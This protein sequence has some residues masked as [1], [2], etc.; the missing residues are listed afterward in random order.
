MNSTS[1]NENKSLSLWAEDKIDHLFLLEF[2]SNRPVWT[3]VF[4]LKTFPT[5]M[6]F[7]FLSLNCY[8]RQFVFVNADTSYVI[9]DFWLYVNV[10]VWQRAD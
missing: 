1:G 2:K 4:M 10:D 8:F 5:F 3:D 7:D 9:G 6:F